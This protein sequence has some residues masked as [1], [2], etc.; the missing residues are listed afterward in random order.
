[1]GC[2]CLLHHSL[3][4]AYFIPWVISSSIVMYLD[5]E[6]VPDVASEIAFQLGSCIL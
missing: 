6:I 5:P 2:H 1:M 4:D 3:I